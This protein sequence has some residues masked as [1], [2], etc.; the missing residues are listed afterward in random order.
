LNSGFSGAAQI[1][2]NSMG[3]DILRKPF[4]LESLK[5]AIDLAMKDLPRP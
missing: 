3:L 4:T 2:A 5:M 1:N